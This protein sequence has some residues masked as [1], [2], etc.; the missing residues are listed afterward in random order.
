MNDTLMTW[1]NAQERFVTL[2]NECRVEWAKCF[3][4]SDKKTDAQKKADADVKTSDL[5][6]QRDLAEVDASVA[7]QQYMMQ[8]EQGQ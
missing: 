1:K 6:L 7:W 8:N 4:S 3:L 2:R 5:R